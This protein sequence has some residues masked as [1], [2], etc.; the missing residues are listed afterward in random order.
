ML[1]QVLEV[2]WETRLGQWVS[3][4]DVLVIYIDHTVL[5]LHLHCSWE[6]INVFVKE[7]CTTWDSWVID[8]DN[9]V[10]VFLH[11]S[12]TLLVFHVSGNI[13]E[14]Y[15]QLTDLRDRGRWVTLQLN[16]SRHTIQFVSL[17]QIDAKFEGL[18]CNQQLACTAL[19]VFLAAHRGCS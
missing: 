10:C 4:A 3:G 11:W 6:E 17:I 15:V 18:T 7:I 2:L 8:E 13:P 14:L 5:G 9:A 19:V 12:P 16:D 1:V